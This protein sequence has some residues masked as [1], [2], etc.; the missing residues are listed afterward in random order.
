[1]TETPQVD[2]FIRWYDGF[3]KSGIVLQR[4]GGQYLVLLYPYL[5]E[6]EDANQREELV[7]GDL[8]DEVMSLAPIPKDWSQVS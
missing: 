3:E 7:D 2:D 4:L 5:Q 1:M 6:V 8:I